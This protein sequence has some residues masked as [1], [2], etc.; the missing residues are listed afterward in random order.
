VRVLLVGDNRQLA[1]DVS[2]CLQVRYPEV[3]VIPAHDGPHAIEIAGTESLD[4]IIIDSL[5]PHLD[6]L[7]LITK[8]RDFSDVAMLVLSE[9]Q[10]DMDRAKGLEAGADEYVTRPFSA[11][12]FLARVRALLRRTQGLGFKDERSTTI[13]ELTI[14]FA[15]RG[16]LLSNNPVRLTPTE[17]TL[18]SQL[19]RNAG[20]V[21]THRALLETVWGAEYADDYGFLKQYIYRLRSKL[22]ADASKPTMIMT[23]RGIG[24]R[25]NKA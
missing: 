9:A 25:L 4:L 21:L 6:T 19:V 8:V 13:G 11:I 15:T 16:V 14:D 12:E 1:Q 2:F 20:R 18:L 24:Y 17:Y 23:Q 3:T 10:T 5:Q 7:D 22:E